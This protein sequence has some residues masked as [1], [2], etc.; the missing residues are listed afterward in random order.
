MSIHTEMDE[1]GLLAG[2]P[3]ET[4]VPG[5]PIESRQLAGVRREVGEVL[6]DHR[7]A[8]RRG[9]RDKLTLDEHRTAARAAIERLKG[10]RLKIE[11]L[12]ANLPKD[13]LAVADAVGKAV[14]AVE[15]E[16]ADGARLDEDRGRD[17]DP[18]AQLARGEITADEAKTRGVLR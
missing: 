16:I 11:N 14:D 12:R 13:H 6:E 7:A 1:L 3:V 4:Q 5:R 15:R 9:R 10:P 8:V 18:I 2:G 17:P